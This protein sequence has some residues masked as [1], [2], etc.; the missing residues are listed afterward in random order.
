MVCLPLNQVPDSADDL[1]VRF[2]YT[3]EIGNQAPWSL[4]HQS[5]LLTYEYTDLQSD[6][7]SE[8]YSASFAC[9]SEVVVLNTAFFVASTK[10]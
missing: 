9:I 5:L 1:L 8:F 7:H 6:Q 2:V 10:L 3:S 4:L